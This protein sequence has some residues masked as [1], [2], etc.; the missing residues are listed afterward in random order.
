MNKTA[1]LLNYIYKNTSM[2]VYTIKQAVGMVKSEEFKKVLESQLEE[3]KA[4][5]EKARELLNKHNFKEEEPGFCKRLSA[6]IMLNVETIFN[7]TDSKIA[8]M[9]LIGSNMGI[10]K[11]IK[12]LKKVTEAEEDI[13]ELMQRLL[14]HEENNVQQLKK[15]L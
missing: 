5:L 3:Y 8:E 14:Q 4:I 9:M 10:I 1:D 11:A 13:R 6:C 15:F 2:G 7:N 12:N